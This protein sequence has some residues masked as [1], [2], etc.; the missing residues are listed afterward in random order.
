[1]EGK[2]HCHNCDCVE[3]VGGGGVEAEVIGRVSAFTVMAMDL[4]FH[5][6]DPDRVG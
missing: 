6:K 5:T 3:G 2:I 1:M 4:A